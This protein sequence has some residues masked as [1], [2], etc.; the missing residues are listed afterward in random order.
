MFMSLHYVWDQSTE[1]P[2][3]T[4]NSQAAHIA[5][6]IAVITEAHPE[7]LSEWKFVKFSLAQGQT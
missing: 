1:V 2:S 3:I 4:T 5:H 7:K 6:Q